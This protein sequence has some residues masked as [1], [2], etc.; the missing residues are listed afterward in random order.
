MPPPDKQ[1]RSR[2]DADKIALPAWAEEIRRSYLSAAASVFLVH[3]VRDD[4]FF[5]GEYLPLTA[6]LHRAFCGDKLTVLDSPPSDPVPLR[7]VGVWLGEEASQQEA[8]DAFLSRLKED[9]S[10]FRW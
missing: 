1:P 3:G 10:R 6:F 5:R 8:R 9:S 7:V 4:V 2:G